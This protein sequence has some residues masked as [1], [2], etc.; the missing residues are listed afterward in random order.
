MVSV[1][2]EAEDGPKL[3]AELLKFLGVVEAP[4][5]VPAPEPVLE[6][7]PKTRKARTLKVAAS[8]PDPGM[9]VSDNVGEPV[10]DADL[11]E[12]TAKK[13][14]E[15]V[16]AQREDTNTLILEVITKHGGPNLARIPQENRH[17]YLADLEAISFS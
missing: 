13:A 8:E 16:H 3:R 2:F 9:P 5:Y 1:I 12:A 7:E 17:A 4:Q 11:S 15:G 6:P 14:E 10:T